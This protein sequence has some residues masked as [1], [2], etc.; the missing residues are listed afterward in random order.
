MNKYTYE[1]YMSQVDKEIQRLSGGAIASHTDLRDSVFTYDYYRDDVSP[2]ETATEI[3]Q[4]DDIG[5]MILELD[6]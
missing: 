2:E 1:D 6:L 5:A 3:L 4:N